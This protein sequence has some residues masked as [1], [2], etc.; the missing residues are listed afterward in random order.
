M[1]LSRL[2]TKRSTGN[3]SAGRLVDR[4]GRVRASELLLHPRS[5]F[6]ERVDRAASLLDEAG[7]VYQLADLLGGVA[8]YWALAFGSDRDAEEFVARAT[9]IARGLDDP[10]TWIVIRGNCGWAAL[11]TGETGRRRRCVP[12]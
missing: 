2:Q 9:A 6:R 8:A 11:L 3:D 4:D 10:F 7:N 1:S 12:R 5:T